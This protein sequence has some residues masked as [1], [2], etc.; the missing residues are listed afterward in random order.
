MKITEKKYLRLKF[1]EWISLAINVILSYILI[2]LGNGESISPLWII[3]GLFI[4][5]QGLFK[6]HRVKLSKDFSII[7]LLIDCICVLI[8]SAIC[9]LA[10]L[11]NTSS[12]LLTTIMLSF[13]IIEIIIYLLMV[14]GYKIFK[15]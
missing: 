13:V 9:I 2:S 6:V 12:F 3:L 10:I 7:G 14:F 15:F 5:G 4:A 8:L 11:I 1:F